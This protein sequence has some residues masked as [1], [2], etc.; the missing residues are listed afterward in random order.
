MQNSHC[1][2][3][4]VVTRVTSL[5]NMIKTSP[6]LKFSPKMS[7]SWFTRFSRVKSK[8]WESCTCKTFDKFQVWAYARCYGLFAQGSK[9]GDTWLREHWT[10][11]RC[12]LCI[13]KKSNFRKLVKKRYLLFCFFVTWSSY[14]KSILVSQIF[15]GLLSFQLITVHIAPGRLCF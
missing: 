14:G 10:F 7:L 15:S 5:A 1:L 6:I 11:G 3:G 2:L 12:G 4:L 13:K 8:N 9:K